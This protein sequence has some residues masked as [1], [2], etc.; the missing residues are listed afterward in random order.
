MDQATTFRIP[1]SPRGNAGVKFT[2]KKDGNKLGTLRVARREVAWNPADA[3]TSGG[4]SLTY[5]NL[6]HRPLLRL[7]GLAGQF[8]GL[9]AIP[10]HLLGQRLHRPKRRS[11]WAARHLKALVRMAR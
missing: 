5:E 7:C 8:L 10:L 6:N 9:C 2:I 3:K 4:L 11:T 1:R